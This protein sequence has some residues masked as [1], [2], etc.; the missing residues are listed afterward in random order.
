[1]KRLSRQ[2]AFLILLVMFLMIVI[3]GVIFVPKNDNSDKEIKTSIEKENVVLKCEYITAIDKDGNT[4]MT[5]PYTIT[6]AKDEKVLGYT[7]SQEQSFSK[8]MNYVPPKDE[9]IMKNSKT[10][11]THY[12]YCSVLTGDI[13]KNEGSETTYQI[14]NARITYNKIPVVI[15]SSKHTIT[16]ANKK[17]TKTKTLNNQEF[18]DK[19]NDLDKRKEILEW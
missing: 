2:G 6:I 19:L 5:Q 4:S 9:T 18:I 8:Y 10:K 11:I 14:D 13:I 7:I 17:Q 12:I 15:D 16:Y 3:L 1:M